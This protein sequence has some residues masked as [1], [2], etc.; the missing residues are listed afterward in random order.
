MKLGKVVVVGGFGLV[1]R[2]L[3]QVMKNHNWQIEQLVIIGY[4]TAGKA[5][6][7]PYGELTVK[8]LDD[9]VF[10]GAQFVFFAAGAKVSQDV[11][12]NLRGKG[13]RIIDLSS[14]FRYEPNVPLVIPS[15]NGGVIGKADLIACPN[16]TT[17]IALMV[18]APIHRIYKITRVNLVS[19]QSASG[20]GKDALDDLEEQI[21]RWANDGQPP[22]QGQTG[23]MV[24]PLAGNLIPQIDFLVP[25]W[26]G[27][28]REEMKT[29]WETNKMLFNPS[30]RYWFDDVAVIATCVRV[31]VRRCHSEVLTIQTA[32]RV[33][34]N[35]LRDLLGNSFGVTLL[36]DTVND[37]YPMPL[38]MEGKEEVGVGRIRLAPVANSKEIVLWVCG[39]QL[40]RGAAL[41]ALE[42]AEYILLH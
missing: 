4:R 3:L 31:P 21:K 18:L 20:A 40:L 8:S 6:A 5:Q 16:C 12:P 29:H 19:F 23:N 22:K 32:K 13:F 33:N 38:N 11:I 7:T 24:Y 37:Y 34:L 17:S 14:A 10:V 15:I 2:E 1:G 28:T 26:A 9:R 41:T 39:D 42:I 25:A 35:K 36:D 27:M 30:G